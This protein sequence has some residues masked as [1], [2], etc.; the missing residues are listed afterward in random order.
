MSIYM[1]EI[2]YHQVSC[3]HNKRVYVFIS[4]VYYELYEWDALNV[5]AQKF[6]R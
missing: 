3:V 4:T 2:K 1:K 6:A 5:H